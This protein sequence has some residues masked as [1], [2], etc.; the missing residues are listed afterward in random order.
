[1]G[2]C[3]LKGEVTRYL[4]PLLHAVLLAKY[5]HSRWLSDSARSSTIPRIVE[6][7]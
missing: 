1:M 4:S 6:I 2:L 5:G 3:T 7:F